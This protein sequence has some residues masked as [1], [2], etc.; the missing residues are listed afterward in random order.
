[1][2]DAEATTRATT[3]AITPA[4]AAALV[5]D[6]ASVMVGGFMGV[7]SPH[8]LITA[9]VERGARDLTV[10][11][12]DTATPGFSIGRLVE[13]GCVARAVVSHIG[14]NPETQRRM[15]A[16]DMDVD[17]VPQGTLIERIRAAG[18]GLGGVLTRTG[19]G[20]VLEEGAQ[21]VELDGQRWLLAPA[22][23][24]DFALVGARRADHAKNLGY[25]LTA[26]N[27]NPIIALAGATVIAEPEDIE[28]IGMISPDAVGTPGVLVDH[29]IERMRHPFRDAVAERG[30]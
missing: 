1:M 26:T 17:L 27:F 10:I 12:N 29:L 15:I 20:T 22:L 2:N 24:A 21:V 8:R 28:P 13:A 19:L 6:G 16:G 11:A 14:L 7:G 4:E 9:L 30:A 25:T 23:H 3:R 5:P 18:V